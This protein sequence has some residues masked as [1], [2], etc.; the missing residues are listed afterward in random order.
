MRISRDRTKRVTKKLLLDKWKKKRG[1]MW[2]IGIMTKVTLNHTLDLK[3]TRQGLKHESMR[4][5]RKR[6][7]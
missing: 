6:K 4:R 5:S 2:K 3:R 1:K 7:F